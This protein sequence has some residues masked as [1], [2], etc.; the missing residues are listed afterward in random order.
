MN[1]ELYLR[2]TGGPPVILRKHGRAARATIFLSMLL[3]ST[4]AHADAIHLPLNGYYHPGRWMPVE[5]ESSGSLAIR[6]FS[7]DAITTEISNPSPHGVAPFLACTPVRSI[8]W[9]LGKA[10]GQIDA[11]NLHALSPAEKIVGLC[12]DDDSLAQQIFPGQTTIPIHLDPLNPLPGPAMAW[13]S[14]D[15]IVMSDQILA[16]IPVESQKM[17]YAAGVTFAVT[18]D[19]QP[20]STFAWAHNNR[21]WISKPASPNLP[22]IEEQAY[23][24]TFGWTPG[25]SVHYRTTIIILAVLVCILA[26]GLTLWRSRWMPPAQIVLA[27]IVM[28]GLWQWNRTQP[29]IATM[30]T[31]I[32][33]T[34]IS[35]EIRD[36]WIYQT[37]AHDTDFRMNLDGVTNPI[38]YD[39]SQPARNQIKLTCRGDGSPTEITGTLPAHSTLAMVSRTFAELR[40]E[41]PKSPIQTPARWLANS[42]IYPGF[43]SV[44]EIRSTGEW[45]NLVLKRKTE[46]N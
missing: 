37:S 7:T 8:Q 44:G 11:E 17:L 26:T 18:G 28:S 5:W 46:G 34:G 33:L 21:L 40:T 10:S 22:I 15:A 19:A 45:P 42:I 31:D 9:Q 2:G 36:R 13:Q 41:T 43:S 39:A 6:I 14:L 30:Q 3:L 16:K 20:N 32:Y 35:P 12:V 4:V 23:A 29:G 25:R 1:A 38:F 24:P 27:I